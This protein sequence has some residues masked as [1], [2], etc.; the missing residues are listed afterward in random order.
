[1]DIVPFS[2]IS[3]LIHAI[4][5]LTNALMHERLVMTKK[6]CQLEIYGKKDSQIKC[7]ETVPLS[8]KLLLRCKLAV[9]FRASL[10]RNIFSSKQNA[11]LKP[12]VGYFKALSGKD[13]I[14]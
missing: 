6:K 1:M 4:I 14:I 3:S 11:F 2:A 12:A 5:S 8:T 10:S 9:N 13:L 7:K